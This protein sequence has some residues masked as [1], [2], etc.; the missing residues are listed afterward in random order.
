MAWRV[1]GEKKSGTVAWIVSTEFW[2][3][4]GSDIPW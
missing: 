2:E 3:P 1:A 4:V